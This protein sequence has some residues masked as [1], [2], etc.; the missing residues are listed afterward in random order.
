MPLQVIRRGEPGIWRGD[1]VFSEHAAARKQRSGKRRTRH[2][3]DSYS[4]QVVLPALKEKGEN[5]SSPP[6]VGLPMEMGFSKVVLGGQLLAV[7]ASVLGCVNLEVACLVRR[8]LR[9]PESK[10][11]ITSGRIKRKYAPSCLHSRVERPWMTSCRDNRLWI[12][13]DRWRR[14]IAASCLSRYYPSRS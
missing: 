4:D 3:S 12:M 14:K 11:G 7:S 8:I 1:R 5:R 2:W 9:L 10:K 6:S 13:P